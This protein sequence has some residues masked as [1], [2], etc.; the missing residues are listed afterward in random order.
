MVESE[1]IERVTKHPDPAAGRV[2][3]NMKRFDLPSPDVLYRTWSYWENGDT[4]YGPGYVT[5]IPKLPLQFA[6]DAYTYD[7]REELEPSH[8]AVMVYRDWYIEVR[9]GD[10]PRRSIVT[11]IWKY[12]YDPFDNEGE[13]NE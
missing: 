7:G 4:S 8:G 5:K 3:H 9:R 1:P 6:P 13:P 10:K 2:I 12:N 11:F